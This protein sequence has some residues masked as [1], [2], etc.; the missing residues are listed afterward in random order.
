[1]QNQAVVDFLVCSL[2][3]AEAKEGILH[4]VLEQGDQQHDPNTCGHAQD[5]E[6]KFR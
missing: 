2:I 4:V 1:V 6:A 3:T 5:L